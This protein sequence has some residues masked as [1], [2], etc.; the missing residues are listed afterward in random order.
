[1]QQARYW[2]LTIPFE[3]WNPPGELYPGQ[4]YMGGQREIGESGFDHWQVVTAFIRGVRRARV[5]ECFGESCH[6][7]PTRSDAARR[8]CFKEESRVEGSQVLIRNKLFLQ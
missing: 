1:M 6:A 7:E 4:A 2:I 3:S 8:Y 5:K